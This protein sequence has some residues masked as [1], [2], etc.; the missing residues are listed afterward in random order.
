MRIFLILLLNILVVFGDDLDNLLKEYQVKSDLSNQTKIENSGQ[1]IVFTRKDLESMQARSLKD[2]L[3]TLPFVY[4]NESRY[5]LPDILYKGLS[6]PFNSNNF[7][8]YIDNQEISTASYGSGLSF[9]GDID[10]EFID[11]IEVYFANPS[12]EYSTEPSYYVIKLYSKIAK[13][14]SGNKILTSYGIRGFNQE[15]FYK[16]DELDK[17]SYFAYFSRVD[18]K[19]DKI[20]N[21]G[22]DLSRNQERY[23]SF[24]TFYDDKQK[25]Q[26]Q[27]VTAKKYL[28]L[29]ASLDGTPENSYTKYNYYHLGYENKLFSV[30]FEGGDFHSF[31]N[32]DNNFYFV[33]SKGYNRMNY[34]L[35]ENIF[36]IETKHKFELNKNDI[37]VGAKYRNKQFKDDIWKLND[38]DMPKAKYN[39]Q[40]VFTLFYEHNYYQKENNIFNLGLQYSHIKNNADIADNDIFLTKIGNTYNVDNNLF[41]KT[42]FYRTSYTIEPYIYNSMYKSSND[43]KPERLTSLIENI[44]YKKDNHHIEVVMGISKK[45]NS[46]IQDEKNDIINSKDSYKNVFA[47]LE[48]RYDFDIENYL[49]FRISKLR[50]FKFKD[51]NIDRDG[52]YIKS[53]NE[54]HKFQIFNEFNIKKDTLVSNEFYVDYTAGVKYKY[55]ENL[56]ISVK[57][58]NILNNAYET[59]YPI[60]DA[61]TYQPL[62]P[63][64]ATPID[65]KVYAT[66]EYMF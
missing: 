23:Q 63:L 24:I 47:Y 48:Y 2:I 44:K 33:G 5:G 7:R 35:K 13:R 64:K 29:G 34:K 14:D 50:L 54:I 55:S 40:D 58:E 8:I 49:M 66:L 65:R 60:I 28:F 22:S 39:Q 46:F 12:F 62:P 25:I 59:P 52:L 56:S 21:R 10:L 19:R 61:K 18:D 43:L 3:K 15:S 9:M 36:T 4:Y 51:K 20:E 17:F 27:A 1:V 26:I 42:F 53:V 41:F 31:L 32:D 30:V 45:D 37:L 57:G 11:H 6:V 38:T 16:S